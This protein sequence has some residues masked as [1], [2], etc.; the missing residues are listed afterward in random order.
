MFVGS[1]RH[2]LD[3]KGRVSMPAQFRRDLPDGSVVAIGQDGRLMVWPPDEW[4]S[5]EQRYR[6]TS[7]TSAEERRLI[8]QLFGSARL[9]EL[10]AQGRMLL[11]PEHRNFAQVRETAVFT[12][13][14]NAVEIVGEERWDAD[15]G[16]LDAAAFTQ[17]HDLVNQRGQAAL[18]PPA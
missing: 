17:L 10:D 2:R 18:P 4:R 7:E 9:F 5:L 11:A 16:Q 12:G 14:G 1:Y 13:V 8:R 3:A 15:T 6:R